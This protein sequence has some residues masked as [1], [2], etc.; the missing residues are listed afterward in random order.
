MTVVVLVIY[1]FLA[2]AIIDKTVNRISIT[3]K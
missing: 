1:E 2:I 3:T